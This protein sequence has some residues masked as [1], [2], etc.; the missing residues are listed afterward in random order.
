[1]RSLSI[2]SPAKLNLILR[3]V[4]KRR[5]GYH[6]LYTLFHRICLRDTLRLHKRAEGIRLVC[7]HP[8]VPKSKNLIVRT[9]HLLKERYPFSGGVTVHLTKR[10]PV[11]GGL[12]GGSSNAAHFLIGMNR[13]YR[14]GL[15]SKD[16]LKLGRR[17]GADVAFFLSG[18]RHAVGR[19]I[20]DKI[21]P[22]SFRRRLWFLLIPD[23]RGLSTRK[24]Y[25]NYR[26]P[27]RW[28]SLTKVSREVRIGS[29]Y[30]ERGDLERAAPFLVN[31]LT[32]SAERLRP[33]LKKTREILSELHLGICRM[34]GSG[35]TFFLIFKSQPRAQ[36]ALR[37]LRRL[38]FSGGTM[39]CHS[40][41]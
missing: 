5:D 18:A 2:E 35:P 37:Q 30:L 41:L 1:M 19:G 15:G 12:G 17:L 28:A 26:R 32:E 7:A 6:L 21:K 33:S 24:V 31:D 34:S 9:F 13:L 10:I 39:L 40:L 23:S 8:K 29:S 14:L 11:G 27:E 16:L 25:Q 3:V 22:V 20:G 4:G 38:G 36:K